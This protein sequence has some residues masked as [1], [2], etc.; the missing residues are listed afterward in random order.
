MLPTESNLKVVSKNMNI[1]RAVLKNIIDLSMDVW[2]DIKPNF[3][4]SL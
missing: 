2:V 3:L 4:K 1:I